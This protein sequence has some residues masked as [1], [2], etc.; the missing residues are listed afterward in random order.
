MTERCCRPLLREALLSIIPINLMRA[1]KIKRK[2]NQL[3]IYLPCGTIIHL[4]AIQKGNHHV[5]IIEM[6]FTAREKISCFAFV[7]RRSI[8]YGSHITL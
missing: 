2:P 5:S 1:S 7:S 4:R 8:L 6:G 3:S